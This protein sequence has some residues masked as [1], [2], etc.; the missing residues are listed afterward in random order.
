MA[1]LLAFGVG[2]LEAIA[3]AFHHTSP[4][5]ASLTAVRALSPLPASE[6]R[7]WLPSSISSSVTHRCMRDDHTLRKVGGIFGD[8][9][10]DGGGDGTKRTRCVLCMD[11]VPQETW[12]HI[13]GTVAAKTKREK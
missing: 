9:G 2:L 11:G 8:D 1:V 4:S 10:S 6:F 3:G 7:A 12:K 5:R 13:L